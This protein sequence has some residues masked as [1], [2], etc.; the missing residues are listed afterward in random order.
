VQKRV[1]IVGRKKHGKTT[2]IVALI[3]ELCRRNLRV[4]GIKHSLHDHDLDAPGKDSY[5]HRQAGAQPAAIVTPALLGV[6]LPLHSGQCPYDLLEPLYRQC[7][8]LLVEGDID[9]EGPKV[10]VWRQ[11]AGGS[12]L[13]SERNDI[14]AVISDE[15]P[16]IAVPIWPR[17]NVPLIAD[18]ILRLIS[19]FKRIT[20]HE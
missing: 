3:E 11:S 15:V 7:D 16:E 13:A 12:C 6:F 19:S 2:L 18:E 5:R 1:H 20:P 9:A 8:L 10:E 14:L 17:R 4:G